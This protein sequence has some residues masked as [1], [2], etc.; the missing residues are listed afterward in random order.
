[1]TCILVTGASG[2]VGRAVCERALS[3]GMKVKGT[4]RSVS[5]QSLVPA[6]VERIQVQTVDQ[7]TDW[8]RALAGVEV[9][10]HLAGRVHMAKDT[11]KDPLAI[12]REVNTA[13]TERLARM[14][15]VAG[16]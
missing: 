14:A 8:S 6:G 15:I 12:H 11:A 5:S 1:M 9:V 16:V 7:D 2:F 10:L 13:G 3:L 4:H